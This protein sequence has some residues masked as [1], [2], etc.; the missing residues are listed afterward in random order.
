MMFL[1]LP[2]CPGGTMMGDFAEKL[3]GTDD[4]YQ[5]LVSSDDA[6]FS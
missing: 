2:N 6:D 3:P 1:T 4:I 5:D